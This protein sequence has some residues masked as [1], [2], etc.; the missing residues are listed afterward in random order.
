MK[1]LVLLTFLNISPGSAPTLAPAEFFDDRET[2]ESRM[3]DLRQGQAAPGS[4]R[5][6]CHTTTEEVEAEG[7]NAI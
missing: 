1:S 4:I 3:Q 2:C 7:N 5:C 6:R